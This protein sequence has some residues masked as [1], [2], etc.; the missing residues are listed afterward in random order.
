MKLLVATPSRLL[1]VDTETRSTAVVES[2]R[3]DY[4]GISWTL[5]GRHLCLG[6]SGT[7][8]HAIHSAEDYMESEVGWV[9]VGSRNGPPV[10]SAPHQILCAPGSVVAVNTGRNALTVFRDDDLFYR[11][12]WLDGVRWDRKGRGWM[13]GSHLNSLAMHDGQLFLLTHNWDRGS[14][15]IRLSWPGL[16]VVGREKTIAYQAHNV[17][18]TADGVVVCNSMAGAVVNVSTGRTL[19][20]APTPQS[21]TRGLASDGQVVFVGQSR[22]GSRAARRTADGGVWMLD[23]ATWR[24]LDYFPLPGVGA[25][26]DVRIVDRP[27][28]CHHGQPYTGPLT[29]DP[30]QTDAYWGWTRRRPEWG[31]PVWHDHTADPVPVPSERW[32]EVAGAFFRAGDR[33]VTPDFALAVVAAPRPR[34]VSV[35]AAFDVGHAG[36]QTVGLVARYRGPEDAEMVAGLVA[37]LD[38]QTRGQIWRSAGGRWEV[39]ANGPVD[40]SH[41][42]TEFTAAG[43]TLTL[44]VNG[45]VVATAVDPDPQPGAVGVRC[46]GGQVWNLSFR[47]DAQPP[48]VLSQAS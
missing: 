39:L 33:L 37:A 7:D 9:S 11:H 40:V 19:W 32:T 20:T 5:D 45:Q 14:E 35:T 42:A 34:D 3:P 4:Y 15:V 47:A 17:W 13:C 38:G 48:S 21:L 31:P 26:Y 29:V 1:L 43:Q 8:C 36:R 41:G 25:V 2:R 30:D 24:E 27:D 6:H 18:P 23:A 16:E 12:W 44:S 22:Y 10:L 46:Q 28:V